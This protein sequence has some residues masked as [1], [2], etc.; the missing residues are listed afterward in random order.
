MN[1]PYNPEKILQEANIATTARIR[2]T[3]KESHKKASA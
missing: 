3:S 1:L 2:T